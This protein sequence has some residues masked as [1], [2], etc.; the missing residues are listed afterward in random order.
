VGAKFLISENNLSSLWV[1]ELGSREGLLGDAATTNLG[2]HHILSLV[3]LIFTKLCS[4][5]AVFITNL[6][7]DEAG[8]LNP[9]SLRLMDLCESPAPRSA[10]EDSHPNLPAWRIKWQVGGIIAGSQDLEKLRSQ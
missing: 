10:P 7:F 4:L 2:E 9:Q 8:L 6:S 5:R 3:E 1:Y